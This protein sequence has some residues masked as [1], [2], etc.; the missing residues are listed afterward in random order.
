MCFY[1]LCVNLSLVFSSFTHNISEHNIHTHTQRAFLVTHTD[2]IK[3]RTVYH[4]IKGWKRYYERTRMK[5]VN[6]VSPKPHTLGKYC[7]D[8]QSSM[9]HKN[10]M[11]SQYP[12]REWDLYVYKRTAKLKQRTTLE[13]EDIIVNFNKDLWSTNRQTNK[14]HLSFSKHCRSSANWYSLVRVMR[15]TAWKVPFY[16]RV[17]CISM[18]RSL[19]PLSWNNIIM[20]STSGMFKKKQ[21][22][23]TTNCWE[24][25]GNNVKEDS[26]HLHQSS[27]CAQ[28]FF[29]R[30][31]GV[32]I[33]KTIMLCTKV[34]DKNLYNFT[35][36]YRKLRVSS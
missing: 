24:I 36:T 25:F 22:E 34:V 23:A 9:I 6:F 7:T 19:W 18:S 20:T 2:K 29:F 13:R 28:G 12:P 31:T 15:N 33:R 8:T 32:N 26:L 10:N 16:L 4:L 27:T 30:V 1:V 21:E 35:C 3:N 14:N 11:S 17:W 5:N